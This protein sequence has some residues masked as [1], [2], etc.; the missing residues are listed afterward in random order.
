MKYFLTCNELPDVPS[1]D[2]GTWR[3]LRV[4]DF[5]S[6]FIDNPIKP[7]E[8]KINTNLKQD[9]QN[10]STTFLSYLIHIYETQYA[11]INYLK[12][13]DEVMASTNQYK[14]ENDFYTEYTMDRLTST[15]RS[16]DIINPEILYHDFKSW[17][18]TNYE[19]KPMPKKPE[20][21]KMINKIIGKPGK[22][23]YTK[24][25]FNTIIESDN[26]SAESVNDLDA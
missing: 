13:P 25:V 18:R 5:L 1:T 11:G 12:E 8:F 7:N 24:I 4:I 26:D 10:W 23:G 17:Y 15:L 3:R 22:K 16:K 9:M 14:M 20:F 2:D 19:G 6:K 21:E